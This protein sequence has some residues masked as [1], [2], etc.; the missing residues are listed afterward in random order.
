MLASGGWDDPENCATLLSALTCVHENAHGCC[1]QYKEVCKD[2]LDIYNR[3]G[4]GGCRHHHADPRPT[5]S[6][7]VCRSMLVKNT[8]ARIR[9]DSEHQIKGACH[10]LPCDV[11][12]VGDY[13]ISSNDP[14]LFGI[15]VLLLMSIELF[16]RK[17]EFSSLELSNFN[18]NMFVMTGE[19]LIEALNLKVKGKHKPQS[20]QNGTKFWKKSYPMLFY[21]I[22]T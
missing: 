10:L 16:L 11:R 20:N 8:V 2:C 5:H 19:Y 18:T 3:T 13:C 12:Q 21:S 6:G 17:Y 22:L 7:N 1:G 9:K 4:T 15:F 14:F